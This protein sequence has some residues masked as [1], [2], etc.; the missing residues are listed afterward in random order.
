MEFSSTPYDL[1]V[2]HATPYDYIMSGEIDAESIVHDVAKRRNLST[3]DY[4]KDSLL[5][6]LKNIKVTRLLMAEALAFKHDIDYKIVPNVQRLSTNEYVILRESL[7]INKLELVPDKRAVKLSVVIDINK[8][9]SNPKDIIIVPPRFTDVGEDI[10]RRF[11][12]MATA[13]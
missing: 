7:V 13:A 9:Y 3:V 2:E 4:I 1:P 11:S 8:Q 10:K 6:T 5:T 12:S